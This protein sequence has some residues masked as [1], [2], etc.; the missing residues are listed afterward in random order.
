MLKF[1]EGLK[2][3]FPLSQLH[4]GYVDDSSHLA[5]V[6]TLYSVHGSCTYELGCGRKRRS[7]VRQLQFPHYEVFSTC[8]MRPRPAQQIN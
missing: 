8:T 1:G 2:G 4:W 5:L 7:G 6:G 3:R